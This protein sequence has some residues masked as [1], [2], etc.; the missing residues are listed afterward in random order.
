M[1]KRLYLVFT[2]IILTA[3]LSLYSQQKERFG[4]KRIGRETLSD[5]KNDNNSTGFRAPKPPDPPGSSSPIG[6]KGLLFLL[7][8]SSAY[9][10][11]DN[12]R[13]KKQ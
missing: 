4:K 9:L 1:K 2:L 13:N 6:N 5:D 8:L 11:V 3:S 12:R 10:I 7:A